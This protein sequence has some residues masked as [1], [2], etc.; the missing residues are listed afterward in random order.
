MKCLYCGHKLKKYSNNGTEEHHCVHCPCVYREAGMLG[1]V[2]GKL[3]LWSI[4]IK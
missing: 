3:Q 1:H 4:K 2:Y